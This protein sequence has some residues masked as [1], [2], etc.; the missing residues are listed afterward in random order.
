MYCDHCYGTQ[1]QSIDELSTDEAKDLEEIA[2]AGFK[3]MISKN[4]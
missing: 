3:I 2:K 1:G 4:H